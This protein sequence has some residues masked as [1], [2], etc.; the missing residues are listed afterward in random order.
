MTNVSD[1]FI[2]V[3]DGLARALESSEFARSIPASLLEW[4]HIDG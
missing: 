1:T 4:L 2:A 3:A